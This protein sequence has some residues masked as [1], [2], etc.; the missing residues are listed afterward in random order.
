MRLDPEGEHDG[1][2]DEEHGR[3]GERVAHGLEDAREEA[4]AT[5]VVLAVVVVVVVVV[6]RALDD[7]ATDLRLVVPP[8][9]ASD[10]ADVAVDAGAVADVERASDRGGAAD[11][12]RAGVDLGPPAHDGE[13]AGDGSVDVDRPA[14]DRDVVD[15]LVAL[16]L[17]PA[18]GDRAVLAALGRDGGR[19]RRRRRGG[20]R[21]R[22]LRRGRRRRRAGV[23]WGSGG[24]PT[25]V[26]RR[27]PVVGLEEDEVAI[28]LGDVVAFGEHE[29]EDLRGRLVLHVDVDEVLAVP[30]RR[31]G[32]DDAPP[33][34]VG[35]PF[36]G[37]GARQ[38]VGF[39]RDVPVGFGPRAFEPHVGVRRAR[40]EEEHEDE[41]QPHCPLHCATPSR[42]DSR[43]TAN[44]DIIRTASDPSE[45]TTRDSASPESP[46][47]ADTSPCAS[48]GTERWKTSTARGSHEGIPRRNGTAP[49]PTK[50]RPNTS[51]Q[52][53][54]GA[55]AFCACAASA[56]F[57]GAS[58]IAPAKEPPSAT[59]RIAASPMRRAHCSHEKA[60]EVAS[61]VR[62]S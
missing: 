21:W 1:A 26:R 22:C 23:A 19:W 11:D 6:G 53:G 46:A 61:S 25:G 51:A 58:A 14:E 42:G 34:G 16:H 47:N 41:T 50:P 31:R 40:E 60:W 29:R 45:T 35:E 30:G 7:G 27:G 52:R 12:V 24:H 38:V 37:L 57:A 54:A 4:G 49:M 5:L 8:Q 43:D 17:E 18:A 9:G 32:D 44:A 39:E 10:H 15:H 33:R 3:V 13:V 56:A 28:A 62:M 20:R 59:D 48:T 36:D 55:W 2:E